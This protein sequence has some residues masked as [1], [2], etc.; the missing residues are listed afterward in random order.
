MDLWRLGPGLGL[1]L[2]LSSGERPWKLADLKAKLDHFEVSGDK[3]KVWD[4][5]SINLKPGVLRLQPWVSDFNPSLQKS[6]NAHV[7]VRFYNLSWEYWHPKIIFDLVRG[8]EV[9]LRLDKAT[10]DGDFR[11]YAK[12][13][14][15]VDMFA[16]LLSSVLLEMDEIHSSF[17]SV[18][19]ENLPPFSFICSSI[20]HLSGSCRWNKSKVPTASVGKSSQSMVEVSVEDTAFQPVHSRCSKMVYRPIDKT[21]QEVPV[22]NAFVVIYQDLWPIDYMVV[23]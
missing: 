13:L 18:E 9:L 14:V 8:I 1:V 21:V 10:I 22:S 2:V 12:V 17:I 23:R 20:G 15:D 19:Y 16:L 6:T 11:Y 4:L 7:W 5:S 3:N